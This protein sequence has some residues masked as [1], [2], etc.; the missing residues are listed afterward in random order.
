MATVNPTRSLEIMRRFI[1]VLVSF[2]MLTVSTQRLLAYQIRQRS[3][4]NELSRM[5]PGMN[6]RMI[7]LMRP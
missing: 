4:W 7:L 6:I 2:A 3:T 5:I 1:A